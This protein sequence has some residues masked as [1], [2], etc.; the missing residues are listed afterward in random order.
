M[1]KRCNYC[2]VDGHS[3]LKCYW[4]RALRDCE[5]FQILVNPKTHTTLA[6]ILTDAF[7]SFCA[8]V[9]RDF[10]RNYSCTIDG[11]IIT[12]MLKSCSFICIVGLG[13]LASNHYARCNINAQM[14]KYQ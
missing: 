4:T 3:K 1:L 10:I 14:N 11:T 13:V 5:R 6:L 9:F 2:T 8:R 12:L 7:E